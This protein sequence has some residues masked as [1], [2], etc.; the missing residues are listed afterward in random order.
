MILFLLFLAFSPAILRA[1]SKPV[2]PSPLD[3]YIEEALAR[4]GGRQ[5]AAAG[6]LYSDAAQLA[7]LSRDLRAFRVD[8]IV[9]VLVVERASA[10]ASGSVDTSR[11]SAASASVSALAGPTRV[12]GPL[13]SLAGVQSDRKLKG[14]GATSRE[15]FLS[16]TLSGRVTHVLPNGYLV[17][18]ALKTIQVNAE[19]QVVRVR[20]IARPADLLSDNVIRSDRLAQLELSVNG[21]GVIG[22]AVR[23]PS[24]LYRLLLG[25]LP[26]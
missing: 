4:S 12:A 18:E 15:T 10:T 14:E 19:N 21:K 13:S 22:D 8:D 16:T 5:Q 1:S 2:D 24:F 25:I 23:R 17:V 9:T 6:S 3:R 20:G 26:F 11:S 7:D